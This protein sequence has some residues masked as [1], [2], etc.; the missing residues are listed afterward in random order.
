MTGH[1]PRLLTTAAVTVC[2]LLPA[3]ETLVAQE[4]SA[5]IYIRNDSD[6]TTVVT[7]RLR[8]AT[9]VAETT[10]LELVYTVD[11]WSSAS[12]DIRSQA[13]RALTRQH[14][15]VIE[16]RDEIDVG[17][18]YEWFDSRLN[19]G[20]RYSTEPDYESHG[21][22]LGLEYDLADK[23]STVAASGTATFDTV[24]QVG[25]PGFARD[26]RHLS[27]R[28]SFTQIIDPLTLAQGIYE[29]GQADG[30]LSSP[31]RRVGIHAEDFEPRGGEDSTCRGEVLYC[32]AENNPRARVRHV[33][34]LRGRRALSDNLSIGA[35][36]RFYIDDWELS[37][38]TLQASGSWLPDPM[39]TLS[40]RY[41]LYWQ[42]AASHYKPLYRSPVDQAGFYTSDKELSP[43]H[44][45]RIAVDFERVWE[46]DEQGG[47]VRT[48]LSLGPTFYSYRDYI[49]LDSVSAMEVTLAMVFEP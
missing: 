44:A 46:L 43:L 3:S 41:R 1:I 38:H 23:S 31:Y 39:S 33:L 29:I 25:D 10:T 11:V 30:Y 26:A 13:S 45:H 40:L 27:A 47:I 2:C 35:G 49:P 4:A 12:I 21:G 20:Y 9:P 14:Q 24:G 8:V 32:I 5:A 37:S 28:L 7:P 18:A 42:S 17:L 19:T 15:R 36:Y 6:H 48:I 16:K 22:S 34:A